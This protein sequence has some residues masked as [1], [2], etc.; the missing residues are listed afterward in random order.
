MRLKKK[1]GDKIRITLYLSLEFY[2]RL[3]ELTIRVDAENKA[4]VIRDA[5]R[6]YEFVI[7]QREQGSTL[8]V[9]QSDGEKKDILLVS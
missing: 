2:Q 1:T 7:K 4:G 3:D 6:L 8:S 5:L 9:R